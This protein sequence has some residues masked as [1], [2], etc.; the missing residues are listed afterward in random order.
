M[1]MLCSFVHTVSFKEL[2]V[3]VMKKQQVDGLYLSRKAKKLR[4]ITRALHL[5]HRTEIEIDDGLVALRTQGKLLVDFGRP[6]HC[7]LI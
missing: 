7:S 4:R 3:A 1:N 6:L 5:H 2:V